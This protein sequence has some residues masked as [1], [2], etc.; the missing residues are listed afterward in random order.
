MDVRK[1]G[2]LYALIAAIGWGTNFIAC[3]LALE[4]LPPVTLLFFRFSIGVLILYG[5]YRNRPRPKIRK[6]DRKYIIGI[7][8]FGYFLTIAVQQ[9]ATDMIDAS[10]SSLIHTMTPV[11]IVFFAVFLLK[12][13]TNR[14]QNIGIGLSLAGAIIIIGGAGGNN[15]LGGIL[16]AFVGMLMWALTSVVIRKTCQNYDAIWLT[17][18]TTAIASVCNIP[19]ALAEIQIRGIQMENF[20]WL[21]V[22][23]ILWLGSI[24]TAGANLWW[25]QALERVP[26]SA[27]SLFYPVMPFTT[28]ALGIV[29]LGEKITMNFLIGA[30]LIV[31]GMI[32]TIL[33]EM[34]DAKKGTET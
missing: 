30:G 24:C 9:I 11:G 16:L 3:K 6:E 31:V 18:Y 23:G 25:N 1:Q 32:Y 15:S 29:L 20:S 2:Y 4:V 27:C 21:A 33:G 28:A 26:A 7:G 13:R 12:E 5:I 10:V 8:A 19:A 17:I 34:N 22:I 14:R